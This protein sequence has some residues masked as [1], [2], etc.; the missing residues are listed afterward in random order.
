MSIP[1]ARL[2]AATALSALPM[3]VSAAPVTI[4]FDLSWLSSSQDFSTAYAGKGGGGWVS[5]DTAIP[6]AGTNSTNGDFARY[7]DFSAHP[8]SWEFTVEGVTFASDPAYGL[9]AGSLI[10]VRN[11]YNGTT[12]QIHLRHKSSA[13]GNANNPFGNIIFDFDLW[14]VNDTSSG[15]LSSAALPLSFDVGDWDRM[16]VNFNRLSLDANGEYSGLNGS[17]NVWTTDVASNVRISTVGSV[18]EPATLALLG[19]GLA[20]FGRLHSRSRAM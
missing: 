20:G 14:L 17:H 16:I 19:L 10:D 7:S 15:P 5:Y 18:P 3:L 4:Y 6:V 1:F 9:D 11:D 2:F 12:D 13:T 8:I